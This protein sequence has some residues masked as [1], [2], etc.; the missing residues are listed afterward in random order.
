MEHRVRCGASSADAPGLG[1]GVLCRRHV[2]AG[3][4]RGVGLNRPS[5]GTGCGPRGRRD[6]GIGAE[7]VP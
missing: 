6:R 7:G 4:G 2:G 1:A 5:G 3:L